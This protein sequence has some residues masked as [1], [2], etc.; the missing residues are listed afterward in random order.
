MTNKLYVRL[1]EKWWT[2]SWAFKPILTRKIPLA[3]AL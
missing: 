3:Q 2:L 1:K